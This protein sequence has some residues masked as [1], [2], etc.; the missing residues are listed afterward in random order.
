MQ[1]HSGW[2]GVR[3]LE[4]EETFSSQ[5]SFGL[6]FLFRFIFNLYRAPS[7]WAKRSEGDFDHLT[8]S[9]KNEWRNTSII[10]YAFKAR[11][12]KT[13]TFYVFLVDVFCQVLRLK[14]SRV[15]HTSQACYIFCSYDAPG[16]ERQHML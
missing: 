8:P 15:L 12:G 7:G 9:K 5:K 4:Q 3:M 1:A 16:F 10:L 13:S 6:F 11:K 14:C 2:S